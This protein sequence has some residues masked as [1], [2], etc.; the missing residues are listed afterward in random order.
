MQNILDT[1]NINSG[2]LSK[3]M[4]LKK[5]GKID[6]LLVDI[7]EKFEV[8]EGYIDGCDL[9]APTSNFPE[10]MSDF[11]KNKDKNI[12]LYCRSGGRSGQAKSF[13]QQQGFN[14]VSH[15]NGGITSYFGSIAQ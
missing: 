11:E 12:V 1:E 10:F 2:D 3:L 14:K 9:F 13:L 15:L 7:R 5:E 6:F 8:E 4:D